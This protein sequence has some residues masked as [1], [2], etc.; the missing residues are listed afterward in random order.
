MTISD[1]DHI[2]IV[3]LATKASFRFLQETYELQGC[4]EH[5][6]RGRVCTTMRCS[7]GTHCRELGIMGEITINDETIGVK[8]QE[9]LQINKARSYNKSGVLLP[10]LGWKQLLYFSNIRDF[11]V[12]GSSSAEIRLLIFLKGNS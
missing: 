6:S 12:E 2:A 3:G 8:Y 7:I 5:A 10:T 11:L 4:S 1:A 9:A